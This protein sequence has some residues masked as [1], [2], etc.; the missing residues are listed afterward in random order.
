MCKLL[1][2]KVH[3]TQHECV[4]AVQVLAAI[5]SNSTKCNC[6]VTVC[7]SHAYV[8]PGGNVQSSHFGLSKS[9]NLVTRT[10]VLT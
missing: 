10:T 7:V 2:T 6:I 9:T 3:K 1:T 4:I 8:I 5:L